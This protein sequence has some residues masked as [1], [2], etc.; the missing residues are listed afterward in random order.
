LIFTHVNVPENTRLVIHRCCAMPGIPL[1]IWQRVCIAYNDSDQT[2]I[3]SG[4]ATSPPGLASFFSSEH[5]TQVVR[6]SLVWV[7]ETVPLFTDYSPNMD[8]DS[9]AVISTEYEQTARVPTLS[10]DALSHLGSTLSLSL[11]GS[12]DEDRGRF[13]A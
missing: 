10:R 12:A 8:Q 2:I 4:M 6:H 1:L 3:G 9:R 13:I 7:E 5:E 11:S